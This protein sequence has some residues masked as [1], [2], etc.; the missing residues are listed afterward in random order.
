MEYQITNNPSFSCVEVSLPAGESIIS[1]AGAMAWKDVHVRA[2]TA[3]R[4]G[5]L[6]G[7]KRKLLAG[8]SFFQ[9][10]WTAEGAPGSITLAPGACGDI[11]HATVAG[12]IL[13]EKSAFLAATEGVNVDSSFNGFKGFFNEGFFV[14][15]CT[16]HGELFF[17]SYGAMECVELQDEEYL[18]DNGYA[19]AWDSTLEYRITRSQKVRSFLFSD[20]LLL[21]F[22]GSG[23]LWV[24]S[25][26]P[27]VFAGWV[28]PFRPVKKN[29]D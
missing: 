10:T 17:N 6:Q 18:V 11:Q 25:R 24:Q 4:G 9:N 29:N 28:H 19:V 23:R 14:L 22:S 5:V 12:E 15:R 2:E 7:L 20:Q 21:R 27:R 1:E 26:S 13:L 16:G 3:S 8:E